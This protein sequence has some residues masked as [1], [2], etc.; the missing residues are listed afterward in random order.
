DHYG[1]SA[2]HDN[3]MAD[4]LD[5][6]EITPY[7][8]IQLQRVPL[9]IHIPGIEEGEIKSEIGGQIDLKPTILHLLGIN[10]EHDFYF[11]NDL[12][13]TDR[14]NFIEFQIEDITIDVH[15]SPIASSIDRESGNKLIYK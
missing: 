1:I 13:A 14:K 12:F 6:D 9:S 10:T 7:D 15:I 4:Y 11:G 3:A 2:T 5:K 8:H